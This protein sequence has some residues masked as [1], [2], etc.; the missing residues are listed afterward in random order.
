VVVSN[1]AGSATSAAA[2][3]IVNELPN[4]DRDGDGLPNDWET[5]N[6]L[7]PDDPLDAARDPDLD[8]HTSWQEFIAGTVPTNGLS[9]LELGI[10]VQSPLEFSFSSVA[11]RVYELQHA[12]AP[13]GPWT[14][15]RS[16]NGTGTI[17]TLVETNSFPRCFY[18]L[19]VSLP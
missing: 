8:G 19:E 18:R 1:L 4:S 16:T 7:N 13:E 2:N 11:G 10:Q 14:G 17:L 12:T 15:L 3:L 9:R 6:G 5:A